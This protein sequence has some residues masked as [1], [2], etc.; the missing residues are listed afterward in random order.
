[1]TPR[2]RETARIVR[3]EARGASGYFFLWWATG[4]AHVAEVHLL[5]RAAA[6]A[7]RSATGLAFDAAARIEAPLHR[8]LAQAIEPAAMGP[9]V[10]FYLAAFVA[11]LLATPWLLAATGDGALLRR[12]LL[13]VPVA[14][15]LALPFFLFFPSV[16]PHTALA[17][18]SPFEAVHPRLE[19]A[20]YVL[21]TRDNT[22]PSL[23]VAL[24]GIL[25]W[26]IL[27][28]RLVPLK[29]AVAVAAPVV[30]ASVVLVRVH[31]LV[32]VAGGVA[33][34]AAAW[35]IAGAAVAPAGR[36]AWVGRALDRASRSLK[37]GRVPLRAPQD[38]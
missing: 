10:A 19:E 5:D 7:A 31:W 37:D 36:L 17:L 4:L 18:P 32:D 2:A 29:G 33:V 14:Y 35:R 9:L 27:S 8:A 38:P 12:A 23:H 20:Y 13:S 16:N 28:S 15:A 34:A 24:T 22:F 6:G 21:T 11:L 3:R 26:A 30:V 1:M 25:S